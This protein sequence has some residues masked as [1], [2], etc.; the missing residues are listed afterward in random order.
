M[1][2]IMALDSGTSRFQLLCVQPVLL[3]RVRRRRETIS[4]L[5]PDFR[6]GFRIGGRPGLRIGLSGWSGTSE[7]LVLAPHLTVG[8]ALG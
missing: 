3:R 4:G 5:E 8:E 6:L 1:V 7:N 2:P